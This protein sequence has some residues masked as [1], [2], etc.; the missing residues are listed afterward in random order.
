MSSTENT[1]DTENKNGKITDLKPPKVGL[2]LIILIVAFSILAF[3][4]N[5]SKNSRCFSSTQMNFVEKIFRA[6]CA[7][8]GNI[9][10]LIYHFAS[11]RPYSL[12]GTCMN[13]GYVYVK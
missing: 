2:Y 9:F 10:Y 5:F 13:G 7:G 4:L 3:Y 12:R 1:N 8:L 6:F 11:V